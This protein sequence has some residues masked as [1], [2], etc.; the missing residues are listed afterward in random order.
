MD[1]Q[2]LLADFQRQGITL[3]L[4]PTDKLAVRPKERLTAELRALVR[5]Y[6]ESLVAYLRQRP[7]AAPLKPPK[8]K[9]KGEAPLFLPLKR[10]LPPPPALRDAEF[11][12][13]EFNRTLESW[14][15]KDYGPC[16]NC[17]SSDFYEHMG[18]TLCRH[19]LPPP[20]EKER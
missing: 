7:R 16:P 12:T 8:R 18:F 9:K 5:Q 6:R 11:W 1:P 20:A 3:R 14:R 4:L 10:T 2:T 19:C 17:Y 13:A 15:A